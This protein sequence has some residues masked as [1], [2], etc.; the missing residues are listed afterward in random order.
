MKRL[1]LSLIF[2]FQYQ[3]NASTEEALEWYRKNY[4]TC[5]TDRNNDRREFESNLQSYLRHSQKLT[6]AREEVNDLN[7]MLNRYMNE[8][9]EIIKNAVSKYANDLVSCKTD[10]LAAEKRVSQCGNIEKPNI[11][12]NPSYQD[13][14]KSASHIKSATEIGY[15]KVNGKDSI[16]VEVRPSVP[17]GSGLMYVERL[18]SADV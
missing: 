13:M 5:K 10:L 11:C 6:N 12:E 14:A 2:I 15:Q 16:I 17:G 1:V 4:E 7:E 9:N 8:N 3:A 18:R